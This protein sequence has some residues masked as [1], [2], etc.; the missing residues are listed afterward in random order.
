MERLSLFY[1]SLEYKEYQGKIAANLM[2]PVFRKREDIEYHFPCSRAA[3]PY[4]ARFEIKDSKL[5]L[6]HF[7]GERAWS[8]QEITMQ[9]YFPGQGTVFAD[10][11]SLEVPVLLG[12]V[13]LSSGNPRNEVHEQE[14]ILTIEKGLLKSRQFKDN[15]EGVRI[16]KLVARKER[17]YKRAREDRSIWRKVYDYI[18][19]K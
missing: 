7:K 18:A 8:K 13:L 4:D 11:V 2:G 16:A 1:D 5:Y 6:I 9:D 15:T 3:I 14:L 17:D 19:G 10:W 12:K